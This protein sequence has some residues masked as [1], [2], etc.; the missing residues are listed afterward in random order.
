MSMKGE[1]KFFLGLQIK[2]TNDGIYIYQT[3]YKWILEIKFINIDE[4]LDDIFTKL[5]LKDKLIHIK[6]LMDMKFM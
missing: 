6:D 5:I 1:L 2:Q 3:K 4:Q